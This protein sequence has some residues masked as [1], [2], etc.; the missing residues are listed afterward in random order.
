CATPRRNDRLEDLLVR[1]RDRFEVLLVPT[2]AL[3]CRS[4]MRLGGPKVRRYQV[5]RA[6]ATYSRR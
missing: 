1:Q 4:H 2:T 3:A 5:D 6:G